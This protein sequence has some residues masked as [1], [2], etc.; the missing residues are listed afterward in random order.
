MPPKRK[1]KAA[2]STT[3][4]R[5]SRANS[6]NTA[7]ISPILLS[8]DEDADNENSHHHKT[9]LNSEDDIDEIITSKPPAKKARKAPTKPRG[10]GGA[11]AR[12]GGRAGKAKK[13]SATV[14][15]H[16]M[17][18]NAKS[19][20]FIQAFR[21]EVLAER[22]R[23]WSVLGKMR[24]GLH[25]TTAVPAQKNPLV[26]YDRLKVTPIMVNKE[27]NPLYQQTLE[28]TRLCRRIVQRHRDVERETERPG[29]TTPRETWRE[30]GE[31]MGR[32]LTY[33]R[34]Y[35]E[36]LVAGLISPNGVDVASNDGEGGEVDGMV[37][38]LFKSGK[39]TDT[40]GRVARDQVKTLL[41][42]VRTLAGHE[43]EE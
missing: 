40:W 2:G 13:P 34:Q 29:L 5:P 25:K 39:K 21:E 10:G 1:A 4:S 24:G 23:G 35:G 11:G 12:G 3:N 15:Q 31:E 28:M 37:T 9:A 30:D 6:G 8:D 16:L 19:K 43:V 17:E 41:G 22:E 33:G 27:N 20:E 32:L 36:K 7:A 42:V 38:E 18:Q 14:E 26:D